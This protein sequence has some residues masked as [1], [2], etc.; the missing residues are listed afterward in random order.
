MLS[1][2]DMWTGSRFNLHKIGA[3]KVINH[4]MWIEKFGCEYCEK[5]Y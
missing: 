1:T 4:W 3:E 5:H 2:V